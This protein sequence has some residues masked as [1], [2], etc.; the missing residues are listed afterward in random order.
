MNKSCKQLTLTLSIFIHQAEN[1]LHHYGFHDGMPYWDWTLPMTQ[2][3]S[4]LDEENYVHPQS[5]QTLPNPLHHAVVDGH[6][7]SRSLR[8]SELFQSTG[9]G[10]MTDLA[11]KVMLAFEQTDFCDF[12][13]Q[14]EIAHNYI[15]ALVGGNELYSMASLRF[16]AYDPIFY[17][18]H[19]AT[20]RIWATWQALQK[21]RGLPYNSANCAI[22]SLRK[23][24]QPFAQTSV[25]NPDSVTRDHS[26]PFDVFDYHN[27]F[28][29]HYDNFQFNGLSIPQIQREL[30]RHQGEDR[31]FAGFMLHSIGSTALIVLD[32]CQPSGGCTKAGEFYL[33]GDE[34]EIPWSY[35]RL[36]KYEITKQVKELHLHPEDNY[37]VHYEVFDLAGKSL[38]ND[39]FGNSTI[40]FSHGE[41]MP[42]IRL[43]A[44]CTSLFSS[45]SR[46]FV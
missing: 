31:V 39:I 9:F 19:S 2:L 36:F 18:V 11:E 12:E 10:E 40:I 21:Y 25:V 23:P 28:H 33:L 24:L 34:Y 26:I 15:H 35:D 14:F 4:V 3:P 38:G 22:A 32:I 46:L 17:L 13:I 16:T 27:S 5:G 6:K 29:Y 42:S 43:F 7:T 30:V 37:D 44:C 41:M 1:A 45:F 8:T 20:D